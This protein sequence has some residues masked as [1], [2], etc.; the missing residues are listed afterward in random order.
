MRVAVMG[1]GGT[2]GYFGGLLARS[3]QDVTFIA[4]GDHL[5]ALRA[6]GLRVVSRLAGDFTVSAQSTDDPASVGPVDLL[7]FCV[8]AYDTNAAAALCRPLVGPQTVVLPLQNG[9]DAAERIGGVL[10]QDHVIG[11]VALV[12]AAIEAPGAIAQT[13]GPGKIVLGE[14]AGGASAR[15]ER[16]VRALE[17]AGIAVEL[18]P[19]IRIALWEKFIF[20]CA[21]SGVTALTRLPIGPILASPAC[22]ELFRGVMEEVAAVAH[23]SGIDMPKDSVERAFAMAERFE[24]WARGSLYH[25]LAAGRRLELETLNGTVTRLGRTHGVPTPLNGAVYAALQ[26]YA[27]GAPALP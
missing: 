5:A 20:I 12:T 13:G 10:G 1:T 24:P 22:A 15:T 4:R 7:L 9:V 18:H 3:G 8:K 14:L 6:H 21:F 17:R 27:E 23:T 19:A 2:G 26:P 16:L 11:G 25:D